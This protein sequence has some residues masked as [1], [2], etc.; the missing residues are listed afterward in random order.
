MVGDRSHLRVMPAPFV[1]VG[2]VEIPVVSPALSPAVFHDPSTRTLGSL[3]DQGIVPPDDR[4]RMVWVFGV[5]GWLVLDV[6][7]H[8]ACDAE[9][10]ADDAV[11]HELCFDGVDI[12]EV[13]VSVIPFDVVWVV[14]M[15]SGVVSRW[16]RLE[17]FVGCI[18]FSNSTFT[19][20]DVG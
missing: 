17:V 9:R 15:K 20:G 5:G 13:I 4:D 8:E 16:S 19:A 10:G 2:D 1:I 12:A 14:V 3:G 7:I 18:D 6:V 11:F